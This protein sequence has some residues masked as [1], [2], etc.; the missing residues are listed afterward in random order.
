MTKL[1]FDRNYWHLN[2]DKLGFSKYTVES[3]EHTPISSPGTPESYGSGNRI[4]PGGLLSFRTEYFEPQ[5][6]PYIC[7]GHNEDISDVVNTLARIWKLSCPSIVIMIVS[8]ISQPLRYPTHG[9][10]K[11]LQKGLIK[12]ANTT[13][14][15]IVTNGVNSAVGKLV[16]DAVRLEEL[17]R[18]S[19]TCSWHPE[20]S[21]IRLVPKLVLIGITSS[22][23]L[24]YENLLD[25]KGTVVELPCEGFQSEDRKYELNP[26]HTHFI[27]VKDGTIDNSGAQSFAVQ[28]A[29]YLMHSD[30]SGPTENVSSPAR[31]RNEIPVVGLLVQGG[32]S[33]LKLA[34]E[35]LKRE[36]PILVLKE[37]GGS[38]D[39]IAYA[40]EE[41]KENNRGDWDPQYVEVFVNSEISRRIAIE[42]PLFRE[43]NLARNRYRDKVLECIRFSEQNGQQFLTF[44]DIY[45]QS[46]SLAGMEKEILKA[47]FKSQKRDRLGENQRYDQLQKDL[48]LTIDWNSPQVALEEVFRKDPTARFK[49]DK[50]VFEDALVK[51]NREDFI[52]LF[53]DQ[54]FQIHKFLTERRLWRLFEKAD[55]PQFFRA[56][57]W[58][59]ILGH[60]FEAKLGRDFVHKELNWLIKSLT[61][62]RE[63][64]PVQELTS[65]A[66][67][68]YTTD[69]VVAERKA[70]NSVIIWAVLMNRPK[71]VKV[72]W[73]RSDHPLHLALLIGMIFSKLSLYVRTQQHLLKNL[74][75]SSRDF[76]EMALGVLDLSFQQNN[77][78]AM[79]A[80]NAKMP[81]WEFQ[82]AV[83]IAATAKNQDFIGHP[84]CQK[85][86]N[87]R[88]LGR[89]HIQEVQR[90][91][92]SVPSS[93]KII[94]SAF[95]IFPIYLWINFQTGTQVSIAGAEED[96]D[97]D[98][99]HDIM[100]VAQ[101]V[102]STR[103]DLLVHENR[104]PVQFQ[105]RGRHTENINSKILRG[106]IRPTTSWIM[107]PKAWH[108]GPK[109]IKEKPSVWYYRKG[110]QPPLHKKIYF[111]WSAPITKFWTFQLTY[112]LYL[113]FFSYIVLLPSCGNKNLDLILWCWTLTILVEIVRRSYIQYTQ[114]RSMTVF[115]KVIEIILVLVFLILYMFLRIFKL[116]ILKEL[117]QEPQD[118]KVAYAARVVL[119]VGLL[120]F[121][122]RLMVIYFPISPTLGPLLYRMRLMITIDF[123]NFIRLAMLILISSAIVI[124]AIMFPD[125]PMGKELVRRAFHRTWFSMFLTFASDLEVDPSC[126]TITT[127]YYHGLKKKDPEACLMGDSKD[128]DCATTG[129]WPYIMNIQ[130]MINMKLIL[131]TLL[132][133]MFSNTQMEQ[134]A[135]A[136]AIW[137]YQRYRLVF[138]F[139]TRLRLPPPLTIFSYILMLLHC[140]YKC[141]FCKGCQK[142]SH[143]THHDDGTEHRKFKASDFNYW[144]IMATEYFR[145]LEETEKKKLIEKEQLEKLNGLCYNAEV[146]MSALKKLKGSMAE[147]EIIMQNCRIAL[148]DIKHEFVKT[149]EKMIANMTNLL[150]RQSPYFSTKVQRYSFS[151]KYV[152]WEVL[153]STYDPVVYSKPR[154]DY[155]LN[156]R[157]FVDED[158]LSLKEKQ[159]E[160]YKVPE[161]KWNIVYTSGAGITTDRTSWLQNEKGEVV[162]YKLDSTGLP[163]NPL[164]RT[165]LRGRG[166]LLRWGPN[167]A[168]YLAITR[169]RTE[170][171]LQSVYTEPKTVEFVISPHDGSQWILPGGFMLH[172]TNP[173]EV[174]REKFLPTAQDIIIWTGYDDMKQAFQ[175]FCGTRDFTQE[176]L[177]E[178]EDPNFSCVLLQR[179]YLDDALNT[180]NA[181]IEAEIWHIH[182]KTSCNLDGKHLRG[183]KWRTSASQIKNKMPMSHANILDKIVH[184][185]EGTS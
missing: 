66:M 125:Y 50:A 67:G 155:P 144:R 75:Q 162:I 80:L 42:F 8:S 29:D 70:L 147:L 33:S 182:F 172:H 140:V 28:L 10:W 63:F 40:Y 173:Y 114:Y 44:L 59:E 156:I 179:G 119:C 100:S 86:L 118:L 109:W 15:W 154:E 148:E 37:S 185:L 18:Q 5:T 56:V 104:A 127:E 175:D 178:F 64:V 72:L 85:W 34:L 46:C 102:N 49:V 97:V 99:E 124:H 159:G 93:L 138:D 167:H 6:K 128:P 19:Q 161:M 41:I 116:E 25:G 129:F 84:C 139:D 174:I 73:K 150:S 11:S 183:M 121:Y 20:T 60:R 31:H 68:F 83:E 135:D 27:V 14:M 134:A 94:L 160:H 79:D 132:Y 152:P 168:I 110:P 96:S 58:E 43:N 17:H 106:V 165:G 57:C 153:F 158:V 146:Q 4:F 52:D 69:P 36:I 89:I 87:D 78:R 38:A 3:T 88:F 131:L 12:A 22:N 136:D 48:Y 82:S 2:D 26:D 39:F 117:F 143:E 126:D 181:W 92:F 123:Y 47:L 149:D 81:D 65:N 95:L 7:V 76:Q 55:N 9:Q 13:S 171:Q 32:F 23:I 122:M 184:K 176:P 163:I 166:A 145:Q 137:K 133:A 115:N 180:D 101:L 157:D 169:F 164:G 103:P 90:G 54:G 113:V 108:K 111:L 61:G 177:S 45:S 16:G 170:G 151:D 74:E 30:V 91:I 1:S 107:K 105:H 142:E 141:C 71:L 120:Y 62:I 53:L 112:I 35:L 98:E 77:C 51:Q 21:T 130:Y 24:A